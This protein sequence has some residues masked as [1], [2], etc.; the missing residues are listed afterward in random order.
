MRK[1]K[2]PGKFWSTFGYCARYE[3]RVGGRMVDYLSTACIFGLHLE[4]NVRVGT[5]QV[6]GCKFYRFWLQLLRR[7]STAAITQRCTH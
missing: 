7:R 1:E 3:R 6:Q 4:A 2:Q 5:E